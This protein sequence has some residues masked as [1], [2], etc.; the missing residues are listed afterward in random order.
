M[1]AAVTGRPTESRDW[2]D[3]Q[4]CSLRCPFRI[5]KMR[6][7]LH[8]S[9]H[10][11]IW[12]RHD[13]YLAEAILSRP[14]GRKGCDGNEKLFHQLLARSGSGLKTRLE[15]GD[16]I[17]QCDR[18]VRKSG[19]SEWIGQRVRLKKKKIDPHHCYDQLH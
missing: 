6:C 14:E 13:T 10:C 17:H 8:R 3:L 11:S 18:N 9:A 7:D 5:G 2:I 19:F 15:T 1:M 4:R 12:T 16:S